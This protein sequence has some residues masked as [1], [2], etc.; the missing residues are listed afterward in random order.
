MV[1]RDEKLAKKNYLLADI[2]ESNSIV[3]IYLLTLKITIVNKTGTRVT[4]EKAKDLYH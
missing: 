3:D 4:I 1:I 2:Y